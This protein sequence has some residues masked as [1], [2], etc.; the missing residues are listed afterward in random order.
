MFNISFFAVLFIAV[1]LLYPVVF[2]PRKAVIK[3]WYYLAYVL[4]FI[5]EQIAGITCEIE[6]GENVRDKEVI[7]ASRHESLWETMFLV[8]FFK[9]GMFVVKK[10]LA[11]I[12]FFGS[13]L[14]KVGMLA[15]DRKRG[16]KSLLNVIEK[17]Q[18]IISD[19]HPI[20]IFPEGT[21]CKTDQPVVIKKGIAMIYDKVKVPVIPVVLN[22]GKFWPRRGF[23]KYP[24][25]IT[26]RF[27]PQIDPG[28]KTS[29]F[30]TELEN[31]LNDGLKN[32]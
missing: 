19:G 11:D 3:Y 5:T 10:E 12:P 29:G 25:K 32:L 22:S 4:N 9:H 21:R 6:G 1:V 31:A 15:V 2:L 26:L 7:Y 20:V 27:L 14:K 13:F 16:A 28:L 17:S 24:G 30:L 8:Y 23:I 18:K